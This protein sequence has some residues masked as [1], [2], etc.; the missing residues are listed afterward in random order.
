MSSITIPG[1]IGE[2]TARLD[3]IEALLTTKG[4]ERAAIVAAFVRL[5]K[6]NSEGHDWMTTS[7]F[8][9]LGISGLRTTDTVALYVQR[10]LD[11]NEG[12]YPEPGQE[13][14]LPDDTW[15][16]TRTGT[17]GA[18]SE[19]GLVRTIERA[20][21]KHGEDVVAEAVEKASPT[22]AARIERSVRTKQLPE[23]PFERP[24]QVGDQSREAIIEGDRLRASVRAA[25]G[26]LRAHARKHPEAHDP[27]TVTEWRDSIVAELEEYAEVCIKASAEEATR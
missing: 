1:N 17:D 19:E 11:A 2:A 8:R 21:V 25:L 26:A 3:G 5:G 15:P 14:V 6:R 23:Q 24:P 4:W 9:N 22:A 10:W 16:P 13:V 27:F 12:V 20:V 18:N 7:E